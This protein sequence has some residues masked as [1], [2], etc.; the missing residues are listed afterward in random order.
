M[1]SIARRKCGIPINDIFFSRD[2]RSSSPQG[3]VQCFIQATIPMEG[4]VPFKTQII[5]LKRAST[6]LFADLSSGTRYKIRRAERERVC[7]SLHANPTKS[8]VADFCDFYDTFARQKNRPPSNRAKLEA[9]RAHE[10]LA[11][12][13]V[14][15]GDG[16]MIASHAYITDRSSER[17]RLLYSASHFRGTDSTEKRNYIGR[18]NRLLHWF[19]IEQ[20]KG[21]GFAHYDLGGIPMQ[22]NDPEKTSIA[23]FKSEF[24]GRHLIEFNGWLS[25]YPFVRQCM[26]FLRR[27]FT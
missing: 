9:L 7:P 24:G 12:S 16:A 21:I 19:E 22:N 8:H 2:P 10:A 14:H 23:R 27:I 11:I 4:F 26:P 3:M 1:I 17:A 18:A 6:E 13:L 20:F 25:S 5:E 15:D